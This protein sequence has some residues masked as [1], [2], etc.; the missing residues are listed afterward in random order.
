MGSSPE[1]LAQA[2]AQK[3]LTQYGP[4]ELEE[5]KVNPFLKF[6]SYYK[7]E[8]EAWNMRML[9]GISTVLGAIG[10][11]AAFGLFFLGECVFHLDRPHIQR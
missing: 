9:L 4:N 7:A 8:P 2:E 10:V 1:G 5:K 6:L 3:R 11:V